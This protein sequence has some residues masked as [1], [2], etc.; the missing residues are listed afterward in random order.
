[1]N[2]SNY[3][4]LVHLPDGV[5][6]PATDEATDET[7]AVELATGIGTDETL[8]AAPLLGMAVATTD[9]PGIRKG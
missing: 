9:V 4:H 3:D 7:A 8:M 2:A 5:V 6:P 1:M